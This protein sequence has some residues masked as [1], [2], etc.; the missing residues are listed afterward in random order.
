[1]QT[2]YCKNLHVLEQN[3]KSLRA[4]KEKEVS[5]SELF[6]NRGKIAFNTNY[7]A[8]SSIPIIIVFLYT[9]NFH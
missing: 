2:N 6:V 7:V 4:V 3:I 9:A 1:M 5:Q 8:F